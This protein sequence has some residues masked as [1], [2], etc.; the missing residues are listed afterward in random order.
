MIKAWIIEEIKKEEEEKLKEDNRLYL[1][2][3]LEN[4]EEPIEDIEIDYEI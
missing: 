1:E 2:L 3:P 4:I